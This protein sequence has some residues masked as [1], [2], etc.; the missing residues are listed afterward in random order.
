MAEIVDL[1]T[2]DASNTTRFYEGQAPSTLNNGGRALEGL[3]ARGFGDTIIPSKTTTGS[4][5]AQALSPNQTVAD[6]TTCKSLF[7]WKAGYTNTGAMTLN[8]SDTATTGALSVKT[9]DGNDPIAGAVTAGGF[10]ITVC[11]G[12][13]IV[14]LNPSTNLSDGSVTLAKMAN[15]A[16]NKIIGRATASTGVPEAVGLATGLAMSGGNLALQQA[17]TSAIGGAETATDTEAKARSSTTVVITPSNLGALRYTSTG[18]LAN[19]GQ[20]TKAHGL[21][22][23]PSRFGWYLECS[24]TELGYSVGDRVSGETLD[25]GGGGTPG[26]CYAD[27]TN[28]GMQV[29]STIRCYQK[30]TTTLTSMDTSKWKVIVWAEY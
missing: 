6:I 26:T 25:N 21:G 13:N 23:V 29:I 1:N 16:A 7:I 8:I 30:G 15:L 14:L 24:T 2:T 9:T 27:A 20:I 3:L 19:S 11:D 28:I 5:N 12:T 18:D 22:A 10:Y 4:A 17:T